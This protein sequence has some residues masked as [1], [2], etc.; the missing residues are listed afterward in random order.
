MLVEFNGRK[1]DPHSFDRLEALLAGQAYRLCFWR[2]ATDEINYRRFFDINELA[3]IRVEDPEVFQAVHELVLRFVQRGWVTGLRI[4]HPDGLWDPQQYFENLQQ[5]YRRLAQLAESS[6]QEC[7]SPRSPTN[8]IRT[9]CTSSSK[10]S[11]SATSR[12]IASGPSAA[13]P[14]TSI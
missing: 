10:R 11:W 4:D 5:A 12:S 7:L 14:A 3:A 13:R 2:V 1:G 9:L 6:E 8:A